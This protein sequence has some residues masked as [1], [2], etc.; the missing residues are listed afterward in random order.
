MWR[1]SS[2]S[3]ST[4][5][6]FLLPLAVVAVATVI[7]RSYR[8]FYI[9]GFTGASM[10]TALIES[11]CRIY[12]AQRL[13][14]KFRHAPSA[15]FEIDLTVGAIVG[16]V[17]LLIVAGTLVFLGRT[18]PPLNSPALSISATL[19]VAY[20]L[21]PAAADAIGWP[22]PAALFWVRALSFP[23]I[24]ARIAFRRGTGAMAGSP[25]MPS[26]NPLLR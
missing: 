3:A 23:I 22:M 1:V 4:W 16:I 5:C 7:T 6:L 26:Q 14:E 25:P 18:M 9:L 17:G 19:G 15:Q 24:S 12:V 2:V 10:V 13:D 21:V 20:T 11:F 8:W